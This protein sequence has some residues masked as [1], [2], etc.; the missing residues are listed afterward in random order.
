MCVCVPVVR[1]KGVRVC[2]EAVGL[3]GPGKDGAI[4]SYLLPKVLSCKRKLRANCL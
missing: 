2:R 3:V 1:G 4:D